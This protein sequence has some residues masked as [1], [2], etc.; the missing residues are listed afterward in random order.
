M[1]VQRVSPILEI[2]VLCCLGYSD[3]AIAL[4]QECG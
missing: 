4:G 1:T 3:E 2:L